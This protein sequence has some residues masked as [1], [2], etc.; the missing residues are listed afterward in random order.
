MNN[1]H[2]APLLLIPN[3]QQTSWG[4]SQPLTHPPTLEA[5]EHTHPPT[6]EATE[7]THPL[8]GEGPP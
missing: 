3:I 4:E 2:L 7:N 6:L 8:L 1:D 5:T